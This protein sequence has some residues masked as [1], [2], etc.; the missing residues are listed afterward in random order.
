MARRIR[1]DLE[2]RFGPEYAAFTRILAGLRKAV[3]ATGRTS[4]ENKALFLRIVDSE[5]LD[6]LRQN[7]AERVVSCLRGLLPPEIDP[8]PIVEAGLKDEG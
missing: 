1:E 3:L 5:V 2:R 8:E 7:D 6:A 4:D